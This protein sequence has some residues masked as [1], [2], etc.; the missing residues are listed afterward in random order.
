[1][2]KLALGA[3]LVGLFAACG[4]EQRR[5]DHRQRHRCGLACNPLTQAGCAAGE[6]CTWLLDALTPPQYVGH[7]GCAP[8]GT[9]ERRRGVHVRCAGR[10]AATT[11]ARTGASAA[12]PRRQAGERL[13]GALQTSRAAPRCA[14]RST[15]A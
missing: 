14:T 1:M 6:K 12:L 11:T 3:L 4:D 15:S 8:D 5:Q 7:I 10:D 13:Q 2:K 9:G